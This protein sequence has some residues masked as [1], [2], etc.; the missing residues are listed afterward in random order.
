MRAPDEYEDAPDPSADTPA[1]VGADRSRLWWAALAA[2]LAFL[3]G[4]VGYLVGVRTTEAS[5]ALNAVDV[6]FLQ[7]MLDHHDQA[8][9]LSL[10]ELENGDDPTARHFAQEAIIFQRREI[11]LMERLLEEGG[12]A[13]GEVPREVMGWMNMTTPL[14]QMPGMASPAELDELAAARGADADRLFL[15]LM[16]EHHRGGI[17]MADWAIQHGSNERVRQLAQQI[18]DYQRIEVNEYTQLM[19]RLGYA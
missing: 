7:D 5:D 15:E 16:R 19:E 2:A 17:H 1:S 10:L 11:G 13:R 18:A 6:G 14:A 4:A 8:I 12:E 3:V 9:E